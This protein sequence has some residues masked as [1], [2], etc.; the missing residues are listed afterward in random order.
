MVS[1]LWVKL[2]RHMDTVH[3]LF[4]EVIYHEYR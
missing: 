4:L 3:L 1:N 2:N